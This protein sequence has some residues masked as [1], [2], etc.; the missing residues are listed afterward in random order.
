[1]SATD[2][3]SYRIYAYIGDSLIELLIREHYSKLYRYDSKELHKMV[4]SFVNGEN[5][6]NI[7]R[8]MKKDNFLTEE[9]LEF[10]R[11]VRN[12]KDSGESYIK[13]ESTSLEALFGKYYIEKNHSR[14]EELFIKAVKE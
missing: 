9:E 4:V 13:R 6:K 2:N 14:I 7:L 11:K 8:K 5:Q 3:Y 12:S 10:I 1:M